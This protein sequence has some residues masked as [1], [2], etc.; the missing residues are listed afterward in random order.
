MR[1][2][3][4]SEFSGAL[5]SI[6]AAH[7]EQAALQIRRTLDLVPADARALDFEVITS[8][9]ADGEFTVQASLHG[10]NLYVL[11][12]A[13][14]GVATIFTVRHTAT[15][16]A[17]PV[18]MVDAESVDFGV[19]DAIVDTVAEWLDAVWR[20]VGAKD[21]GIPVRIVGHD[22]FGTTTPRQLRA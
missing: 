8:Q 6:L 17:P 20:A 2:M 19:N 18:P 10:P 1:P 12:K 22:D 16:F 21:P 15:G 3:T 5:R 4:R 14:R 11:N 9:D 7:S 13:I